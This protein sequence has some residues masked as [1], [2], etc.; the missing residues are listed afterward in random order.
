MFNILERNNNYTN[1][2]SKYQLKIKK[3]NKIII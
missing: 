3:K 2:E 1:F